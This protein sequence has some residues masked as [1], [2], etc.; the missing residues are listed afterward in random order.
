[1]TDI[2][3]K[4]MYK[5]VIFDKVT[6]KKEFEQYK[7]TNQKEFDQYK[8][9]NQ[10]EFDLYKTTQNKIN[11]KLIKENEELNEIIKTYNSV[12]DASKN[13]LTDI[14]FISY[15]CN[16]KRKTLFGY[17]WKYLDS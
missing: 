12:T 8:I 6:I 1:M 16:G 11:D 4:K 7:I 17:K 14:P 15:P 5:E 2:D 3:Y 9:T 13:N 10:K